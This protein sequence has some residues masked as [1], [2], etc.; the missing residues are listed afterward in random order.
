MFS[1]SYKCILINYYNLLTFQLTL[2]RSST[3]ELEDVQEDVSD[4][5]DMGELQVSEVHFPLIIS[6]DNNGNFVCVF[7]CTIVNL[8]TYRQFTNAA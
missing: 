2:K 3:L 7:E 5:I 6:F 8:A 1:H 4:D